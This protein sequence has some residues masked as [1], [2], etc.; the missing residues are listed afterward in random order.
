MDI[1]ERY[2]DSALAGVTMEK[3]EDGNLFA[4]IPGFDG[5]WGQG[6]TKHE[7]IDYLRG[8]LAGWLL[9]KMEDRD[10]DIPVIDDIN[11]NE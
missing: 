4:E 3:M 5:V 11:L 8:A 1:P 2:L 7:A 9:L 10:G 6:K